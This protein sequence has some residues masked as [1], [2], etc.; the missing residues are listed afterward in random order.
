[1]SV[2]AQ[3]VVLGTDL[4]VDLIHPCSGGPRAPLTRP[5]KEH[6][7]K[8]CQTPLGSNLEVAA[9]DDPRMMR[10]SLGS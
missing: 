7:S 5:T 10:E 8:D 3:T 4:S 6:T 1:M 9:R 2:R